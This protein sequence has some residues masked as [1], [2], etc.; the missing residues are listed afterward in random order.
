M[1]TKADQGGV[2]IFLSS[3]RLASLSDTMFGVAMTLVVTTLLPSI[4]AQK[5]SV[6]GMLPAINGELVTVV[7]SFAI[8]ARYWV[9]Q[10][11]RL[12]ATSSVTPF[13]TWLHLV[14]LFLI[15]LVPISTSLNGLTGSD[16][17]L[18]SVMIYGAHLLLIAL[19]NLL[20]WI[21]VHRTVGAHLQIVRSSLAVALFVVALAV[22]AMRPDLALYLWVAVLATP[23]LAPYLT[24]RVYGI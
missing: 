10:Q 11:Q 3:D 17:K 1:A 6:L 21:E 5:G 23:P 2:S 16:A 20:L 8:S 7:L 18:G 24:R 15:V 13:Q 19:V 22:G 4:Q 12:A 14:F 9:S